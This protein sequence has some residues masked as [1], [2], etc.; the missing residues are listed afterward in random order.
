MIILV[1]FLLRMSLM[2]NSSQIN[3][4]SKS[5]FERVNLKMLFFERVI[6]KMYFENVFFF[7]SKLKMSFSRVTLKMH[8]LRV[9]F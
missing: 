5:I 4:F 2:K 7:G 3:V 6:L 9:Q 1:I 8:F